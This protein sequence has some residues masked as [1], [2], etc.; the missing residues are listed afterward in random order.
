M[1]KTPFI[2]CTRWSIENACEYR[3]VYEDEAGEKYIKINGAYK[4]LKDTRITENSLIMSKTT[5]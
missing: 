1:K 3:R 2:A 5:R 4:N